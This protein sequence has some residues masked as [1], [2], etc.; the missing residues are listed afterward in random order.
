[1]RHVLKFV[2][3]LAAVAVSV[4]GTAGLVSAAPAESAPAWGTYQTVT[5]DRV[6]DTRVG[7]GAPQAAVGPDGTL[8]VNMLGTS[9]VPA[10]GVSAV[11]LNLTVTAATKASFLTVWP[12]GTAK[13]N[14]SSINF[15]AGTNRANLVTV[16][17]GTIGAD[18]GKIS[19]WNPAG[20]VQV[21]ADVMGYYKT[22]AAATPG[23][24]YQTEL[25]PSRLLDTRDKAFGGP[26]APGESVPVAVDYNAVPGLDL[27]SHVRALAVN[28]TAVNPTKRGFLAA[29]DGGSVLPET[30]TVNFAAGTVT[31]NMAI[32]PVGPCVDCGPATGLPSIK[33]INQSSGTTHVLV[34]IVGLYDDGQT[35]GPD[36][37]PMA[38]LRFRPTDPHRIVDTRSGLGATTFKG[39]AVNK[40]VPM[41]ARPDAGPGT[42][43]LVTNTT[44]VLP[45]MPTFVT[46]WANFGLPMPKVSNL[47]TAKGQTVANATITDLGFDNFTKPRFDIYNNQGTVDI[48]V[49]VVGTMDYLSIEPAAGLAAPSAPAKPKPWTRKD[50]AQPAAR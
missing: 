31:P 20:T 19:I 46:L 43:S 11:V 10:S 50:T 38:G 47:N 28:I 45:T 23:G 40:S 17:V 35:V 26:L 25:I 3:L 18:T 1:L 32:V 29:Y 15:V 37:E 36:G 22:D 8:N 12:S 33:I 2:A 42:F 39:T 30:S 16:P 41:P 27:N 44:A 49:D 9:G 21:I 7:T 34:D 48:L 6:L 5:P 14:V 13:P 24:Y 4:T